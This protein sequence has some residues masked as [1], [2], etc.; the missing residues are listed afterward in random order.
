MAAHPDKCMLSVCG[1][2]PVAVGMV[3][4]G[5]ELW[6]ELVAPMGSSSSQKVIWPTCLPTCLPGYL[7]ACLPACLPS[8][9]PVCYLQDA[10]DDDASHGGNLLCRRRL[11]QLLET[12][13]PFKTNCTNPLTHARIHPTNILSWSFSNHSTTYSGSLVLLEVFVL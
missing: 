8:C 12:L 5:R 1:C 10:D 3:G 2:R 9:L 11:L 7:P 4:V 13:F 6:V